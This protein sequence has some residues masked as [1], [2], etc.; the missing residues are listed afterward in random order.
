LEQEV[1]HSF[2]IKGLRCSTFCSTF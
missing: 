2:K 1:E